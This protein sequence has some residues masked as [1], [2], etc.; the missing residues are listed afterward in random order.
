[1]GLFDKKYCDI[2]GEKI[3]LLG[4]R[5]LE[6][7]NLCK[8]CAKKLSPFFS[9]RRNSTV[10]E[11]RQQLAY[12]EENARKLAGF[13]PDITFGEGKKVYIDRN[14]RQLIVTSATNWHAVNPD[15]IQFSMVRDV[16]TEI[17][18]NKTEIY[19]KDEEG[20][21]RSYQPRRYEC[22]YA[23]CVT[24]LVDSPW[25]D[26]IELELS[27]GNRPDSPY[28]DLYRQYEEQMHT[29]TAILKAGRFEPA[30]GGQNNAAAAAPKTREQ[31]IMEGVIK[32]AT[33]TCKACGLA[34]QGTL[35]CR[36]CGGPVSDEKILT[37]AGNIAKATLMMENAAPQGNS[38]AMPQSAPQNWIC[39]SC[40]AQNSSK[41]CENCGTPRA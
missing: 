29:L 10:E 19:Y 37:I 28:T 9:D 8:D 1:M 18:E 5:K 22:D 17:R 14:G 23:F 11:I 20:K 34:N 2:C 24:I 16:K 30:V 21:R 3:G 39:P 41:F 25:F 31:E 26:Q 27:S 38:A 15:L 33:W 12:R 6:D 7:G 13:Q 4:N 36:Q 40:G 35:T 32:D